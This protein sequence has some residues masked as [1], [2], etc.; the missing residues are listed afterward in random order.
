MLQEV[1]DKNL[2]SF[3]FEDIVTVY[4]VITSVRITL[5]ITSVKATLYFDSVWWNSEHE[6]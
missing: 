3:S 4:I 1:L 2:F 5:N 6:H